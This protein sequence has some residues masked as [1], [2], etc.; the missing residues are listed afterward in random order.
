MLDISDII[1]TEFG[2]SATLNGVA[3]ASGAVVQPGAEMG[4]LNNQDTP[5]QQRTVLGEYAKITLR[6]ADLP[7]GVTPQYRDVVCE[8]DREWLLQANILKRGESYECVGV[9]QFRAGVKR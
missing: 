7:S 3:L 1:M 9:R 5:V 4:L 8:G 6:V 2:T